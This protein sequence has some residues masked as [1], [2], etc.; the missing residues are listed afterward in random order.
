MIEKCSLPPDRTMT[1]VQHL[2]LLSCLTPWGGHFFM[3]IILIRITA[4]W[5]DSTDFFSN[6]LSSKE[7]EYNERN[8]SIK[9]PHRQDSSATHSIAQGF[10]PVL[11]HGQDSSVTHP[12]GLDFSATYPNAHDS[13]AKAYPWKGFF[14]N[15]PH[16]QGS[17]STPWRARIKRKRPHVRISNTFPPRSGWQEHLTRD[18]H[19]CIQICTT[20]KTVHTNAATGQTMDILAKIYRKIYSSVATVWRNSK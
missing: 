19:N 11:P 3:H 6:A 1:L 8:S 14:S 16:A 18:M 2:L 10:S 20:R 5:M 12:H 13:S 7:Q 17:I 9:H 4:A 15:R